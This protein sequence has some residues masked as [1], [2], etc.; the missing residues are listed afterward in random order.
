VSRGSLEESTIREG[1]DS[2]LYALIRD[3]ECRRESDSLESKHSSQ[4]HLKMASKLAFNSVDSSDDQDIF[5]C[6]LLSLLERVRIR[7]GCTSVQKDF[8]DFK[9]IKVS[10]QHQWC[11]VW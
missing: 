4:L 10:C 3:R 7:D 6:R 11:E 9:I 8:N 5:Y 2:A 1:L